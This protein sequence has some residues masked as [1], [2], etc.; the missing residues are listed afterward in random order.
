MSMHR[1]SSGKSAALF[2]QHPRSK[3]M[4]GDCDG[5]RAA[6]ADQ[7][8]TML[9]D[10]LEQIAEDITI[11]ASKPQSEVDQSR[12]KSIQAAIKKEETARRKAMEAFE[13]N[14]YTIEELRERKS[15]A[16]A[17]IESL[18]KRLKDHEP[19]RVSADAPVKIRQCI[20]LLRDEGVSA[21]D[22]NDLLK[23]I[24]ER[25]DYYNDTPPYVL[26]NRIRLDVHLR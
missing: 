11:E 9:I 12:I 22:K 8:T 17:A 1:M 7:V 13:A 26:P 21:Q 14:I 10:A 3:N 2:Y 25:I 16:D 18:K 23:S 20:D 19:K 5:C 4:L 15:K 24:I 6:R